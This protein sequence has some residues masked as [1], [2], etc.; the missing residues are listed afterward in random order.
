M[1]CVGVSNS[2]RRRGVINTVEGIKERADDVDK[3]SLF[4]A[5]AMG[6]PD[7]ISTVRGGMA[8]KHATQRVVLTDPE[9]PMVYTGAEN[10]YGEKSSWNIKAN[11]D[12]QLMKIFRKFAN[13]PCSPIAYIFK[14]LDTGKYLCKVIKPVEN[15][16]EKYGFR[17][18]SNMGKYVEGDVIQSGSVIAQSVSYINDNYCAGKNVRIANAVLP[19]LTEDALVVSDYVSEALRY[20]MV[21]VVKVD[22]NRHAFLLNNYGDSTLYKPFPDIGE[23]VRDNI[24]CS[25]RE[26][27]YLSTITE[28]SIPH[29]KDRNI[30]TNGTLVDIDIHTNVEVENEQF[31]YYLS[32]IRDWYSDI[33]SY[34]STII[35]DKYQDD[36]SLLDIY[37]QAEKYLNGSSWVTKEYVLDTLIKF[38]VL[39]PKRIQ[40]GQKMVGRYGNKATVAKIIPRDLMPKTD[41]GRPI[42]ILSNALAVPN[43]IIAFSLYENTMTFQMDRMNQHI[44]KMKE[45]GSTPDEIVNLVIEFVGIYNSVHAED[46]ARLYHTY[47]DETYKDIITNGIFLQ[48]EP[49]N[50]TCIRDAILEAYEKFPDIL[51]E[52]KLYTKLRHRWIEHEETFAIGYQYMWVLKQEPSK[53]MSTVSTGRTTLYDLPV[54]TRQYNKNLRHYSDNPIKFGEYD[55][56]NFLAGVGIKS[57]AKISSYFRGSQYEENSV[58]MSHL[59]N[60]KIDT[61]KYNKFPQ[62]DNLKNVLKLMG[63]RMAP[64]VFG[65]NTIGNVDDEM[66]LLF[67]NVTVKISIPDLRYILIMYSYYMQYESYKNGTVDMID[68]FNNIT[69]T[70]LFDGVTD[71]AYINT[72]FER[73]VNLLPTLQQLKQYQ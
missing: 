7:K 5:S 13:V 47:P 21:D 32:Q 25:I 35:V 26:N 72:V 50:D 34:I 58:L 56:Y 61:S 63:I 46:I 52:Y 1:E 73:F 10:P 31:N 16:V 28:A 66:D 67:N 4:G 40:I 65:Y 24:I 54:K 64:D 22:I 23:E 6:F 59:N 45:A 37:H 38:T 68:F 29:I 53:S 51:K 71:Q 57:F 69:K 19:E 33:Y 49:L 17:M 2:R 44:L 18:N 15:L 43:R 9:F 36:T 70:N 11:G 3:R 27:S 39:Q 8:T 41:D 48:V 30:F 14:N 55:T 42:D 60:M 12:Y 20:D 62:L